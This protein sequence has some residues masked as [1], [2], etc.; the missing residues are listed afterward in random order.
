MLRGMTTTSFWADDVVAARDWYRGLL[1][2]DAYFQRP[3]A[4]D[5]AYVEFRVGDHQHG[6]CRGAR[7]GVRRRRDR[8]DPDSGAV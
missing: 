1:S 8:L 3:D 5:P 4:V 2:V 6:D 7:R